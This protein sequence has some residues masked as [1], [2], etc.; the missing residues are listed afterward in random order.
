M[1]LDIEPLRRRL[2]EIEQLDEASEGELVKKLLI[3]DGEIRYLLRR[4]LGVPRGAILNRRGFGLGALILA[5]LI[6]L[7]MGI[8]IAVHRPTSDLV[9]LVGGR[10]EFINRILGR[11]QASQPPVEV[12]PTS[13]EEVSPADSESS[14]EAEEQ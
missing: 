10:D 2:E 3:L 12:V 9:E 7:F 6:A 4:H 8:W 1:G 5:T 13:L 11:E 14:P